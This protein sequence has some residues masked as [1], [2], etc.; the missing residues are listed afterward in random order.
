[1]NPVEHRA[2]ELLQRT[3]EE[4]GDRLLAKVRLAD[5]IDVGNWGDPHR[6][7]AMR[8]HLDFLMIN[9]ATSEPLFA[10]EIDG[11]RHRTDR[12]QRHRDVLK[13]ELCKE[14]RLPLLRVGSDFARKEGR[15]VLLDYL[16][17]AYYRSVAFEAA[18][19]AGQSPP[20]EPFIRWA[21]IETDARS[22]HIS[23]SGLDMNARAELE[24][25]YRQ[26]RIP[27]FV[28]DTWGGDVDQCGDLRSDVYLGVGKDLTL[29]G[30]ATVRHFGWFGIS[31]AEFSEELA[32]SWNFVVT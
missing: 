28:R 7:F 31:A 22:G 21:F 5:A 23:L 19:E 4:R 14:A 1:M 8:A 17:E 29:V 2:D 13:D 16:C 30:S 18:Q 9:V 11:A 15:I 26:E 24:R 12:T 32:I 3:A 6:G 20:D 25:L 27:H 10:V